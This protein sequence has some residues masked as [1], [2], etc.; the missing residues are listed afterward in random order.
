M[1]EIERAGR[2]EDVDFDEIVRGKGYEVAHFL[3]GDPSKMI[4]NVGGRYMYRKGSAYVPLKPEDVKRL[5]K[6]VYRL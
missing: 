6:G 5:K 4:L 2:I 1:D 3:D